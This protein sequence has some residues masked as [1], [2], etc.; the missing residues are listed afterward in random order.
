MKESGLNLQILNSDLQDE[1]RLLS[2]DNNHGLFNI[3]LLERPG[4]G[5]QSRPHSLLGL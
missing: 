5:L 3:L 2:V 1:A 4:Q